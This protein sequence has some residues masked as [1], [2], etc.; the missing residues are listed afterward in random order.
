M[1]YDYG[2]MR[3]NFLHQYLSD[4][5]GD[6]AVITHI[7]D[8][9]RKFNYMG[10]VQK[11]TGEICGK[12]NEGGLNLVDVAVRF[13]NQRGDETLRATATIA[14]PSKDKPLPL[15]PSVPAEL[16]EKAVAMMARHWELGGD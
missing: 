14:L 5:C 13:V 8:E 10:D 9:V 11:V 3:E 6:D 7:H 15:Y 16:A 2:V 12:R 1:A 4:W